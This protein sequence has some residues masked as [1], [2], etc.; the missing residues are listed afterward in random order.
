MS[1]IPKRCV[2]AAFVL[3]VAIT[4]ATSCGGDSVNKAAARE[5]KRFYLTVCMTCHGM[6]GK[7]DGPGAAPLDPKPRS[8]A[9][10]EW[11]TSVTDEHIA[12]VILKGGAAVGLSPLMLPQPALESK[13]E[14]LEGLVDFVR[15]FGR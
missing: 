10:P 14:V 7:G 9:D 1:I 8:F 12:V 15:S 11:Q 5:A 4:I 3:L 6:T 2:L 13:P